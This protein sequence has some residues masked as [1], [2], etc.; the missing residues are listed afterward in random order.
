MNMGI[1]QDPSPLVPSKPHQFGISLPKETIHGNILWLN[2]SIDANTTIDP[3]V[4]AMTLVKVVL[5]ILQQGPNESTLSFET[6]D[7]TIRNISNDI[8]VVTKKFRT[9]K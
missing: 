5:H 4:N 3:I 6:V 1:K 7:K 9:Q 2:A 8:N